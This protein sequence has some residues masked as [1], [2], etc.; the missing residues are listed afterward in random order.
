VDVALNFTIWP[1]ASSCLTM[2]R[3]AGIS[4]LVEI[5]DAPL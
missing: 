5:V 3:H 1:L 2:G 4:G